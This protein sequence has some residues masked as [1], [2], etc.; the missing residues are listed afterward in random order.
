MGKLSTQ[1]TPTQYIRLRG[2]LRTGNFKEH[3][4]YYPLSQV[5]VPFG[6]CLSVGAVSN[7]AAETS[8][9]LIPRDL[10][11]PPL[12]PICDCSN[13]VCRHNT[14]PVGDRQNQK[15][16]FCLNFSIQIS[17]V[18]NLRFTSGHRA[19]TRPY[20]TFALVYYFYDNLPSLTVSGHL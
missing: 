1:L 10:E 20:N 16:I 3:R 5:T 19:A 2:W 12:A 13:M 15:T 17:P 9:R 8:G 7:Y 18:S 4:I 11:T 14:N 6:Y